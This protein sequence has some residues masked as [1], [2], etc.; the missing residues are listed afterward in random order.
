MWPVAIAGLAIALA[1]GA[2]VAPFASEYPDGLE[3]LGMK[4]GF[5]EGEPWPPIPTPIL[6]DSLPMLGARHVR[7]ATS[8]A[9]VVGTLVVFGDGVGLS[10]VFSGRGPEGVSP[11]AA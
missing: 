10:R 1:I 3:Y 8:V 7:L 4:L 6:Y 5:L 9:G 11:D 2:F